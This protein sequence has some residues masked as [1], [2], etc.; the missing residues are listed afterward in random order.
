MINSDKVLD[1]CYRIIKP[2]GKLCFIDAV[3]DKLQLESLPDDVLQKAYSNYPFLKIGFEK[4]L[5]SHRFKNIQIEVVEKRKLQ[6]NEGSL[7]TE[8]FQNNVELNIELSSI[9]A[10][11]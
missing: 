11:K 8:A 7:A 2:K 5:S 1:E 3:I 6:K 10:E 4:L 9:I